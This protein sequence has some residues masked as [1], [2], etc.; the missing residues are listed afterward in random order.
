MQI[1]GHIYQQLLLATGR[2]HHQLVQSADCVHHQLTLRA[3]HVYNQSPQVEGRIHRELLQT[4]GNIH[5]QLLMAEGR[6]HLHAATD[7]GTS[8][9]PTTMDSE[10]Y[11][12]QPMQTVQLR[13]LQP[14]YVRLGHRGQEGI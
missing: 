4:A 9:S 14:L 5:H 2:T 10:T 13:H 6:T 12:Q 1:G 7:G 3:E 11:L 8:S